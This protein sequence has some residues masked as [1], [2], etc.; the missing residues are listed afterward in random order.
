[1]AEISSGERTDAEKV[2]IYAAKHFRKCRA[3]TRDCRGCDLEDVCA[4]GES[5]SDVVDA[6]LDKALAKKPCEICGGLGMYITND[7]AGEI[8]R[9]S[10][11]NRFASD[12][13]ARA[14]V[15]SNY[16]AMIEVRNV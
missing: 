12:G 8:L 13:V 4:S 5:I 1:M 9:C 6:I 7:R 16:K 3:L 10:S 15:M 14:V 11:C 2:A